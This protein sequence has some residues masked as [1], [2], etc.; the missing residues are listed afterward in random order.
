MQW[1]QLTS[2]DFARAVEECRGVTVLPVGVIEAHASHLPLGTDTFTA[3]W[4]ACRAAE[5]EAAVVFPFYPYGINSESVHLPGSVALDRE[6]VFTLLERI[7]DEIARNGMTKIILHSGHGGNRYF[8]PLFVQT[9]VEKDKTY[10]AYYAD[11]PGYTNWKEVLDTTETGHA[12]EWETSVMLHIHE[13]MVRMGQVP[14]KPFTSLGRNQ[15]LGE[16]DTGGQRG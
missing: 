8:L 14:S 2:L 16:P 11:L 5:K 1:E 9:L 10:Q 7:C 3:H 6:L 4:V 15:D 13:E 12:C